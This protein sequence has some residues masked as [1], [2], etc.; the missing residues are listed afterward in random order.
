MLKHCKYST[1]FQVLKITLLNKSQVQKIPPSTLFLGYTAYHMINLCKIKHQKA[2][3][4]LIFSGD[5]E[6]EH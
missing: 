4:F 2:S 1:I 5:I 6:M 3:D